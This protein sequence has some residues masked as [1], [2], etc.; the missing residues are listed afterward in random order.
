MLSGLRLEPEG[1]IVI[2]D[3]FFYT[4]LAF[5]AVVAVYVGVRAGSIA[6]F[7]TKLEYLRHEVKE[8]KK[9]EKENG[10]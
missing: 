8:L 2:S 3:Y 5:L 9:G 1:A 6:Y 7:R 4:L 10:V